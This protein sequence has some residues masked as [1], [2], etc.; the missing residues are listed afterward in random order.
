ML[1]TNGVQPL[2][3]L[4]LTIK[5]DLQPIDP[6]PHPTPTHPPPPPMSDPHSAQPL[7]GLMLSI[8]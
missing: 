2:V 4:V 8:K 3:I 5:Q 6:H 1:T 7:A